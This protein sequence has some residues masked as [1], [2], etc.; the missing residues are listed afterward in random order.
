MKKDNILMNKIRKN[1][2]LKIRTQQIKEGQ[3]IE[4]KFKAGMAF[5]HKKTGKDKKRI[6]KDNKIIGKD[7]K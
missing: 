1:F 4:V 6:A 5:K 2:N 3:N 7:N